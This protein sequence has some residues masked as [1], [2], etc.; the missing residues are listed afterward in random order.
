MIEAGS[1][2]GD[3]EKMSTARLPT[4]RTSRSDSSLNGTFE[5]ISESEVQESIQNQ[6][7][8]ARES[9]GI[10]HAGL[11]KKSRH[12]LKE[13]LSVAHYIEDGSISLTSLLIFRIQ[14]AKAANF[15][16]QINYAYGLR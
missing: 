10:F 9:S 7:S 15:P 4:L 3:D 8:E 16:N 14:M 6:A 5:V 12:V 2:E 1:E 11:P 13:G